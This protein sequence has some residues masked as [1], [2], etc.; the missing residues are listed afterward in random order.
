MQSLSYSNDYD[1]NDDGDKIIKRNKRSFKSIFFNT[2]ARA[3]HKEKQGE[4][5]LKAK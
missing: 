3:L 4:G 1:E 2:R 5:T